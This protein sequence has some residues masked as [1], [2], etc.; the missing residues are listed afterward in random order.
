MKLERFELLPNDIRLPVKSFVDNLD[1]FYNHIDTRPVNKAQ[2][3]ALNYG[4]LEIGNISFKN[5][6]RQHDKIALEIAHVVKGNYF[7]V[8][9]T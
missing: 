5:L 7:N 2:W 3:Q 1:K 4:L 8:L 9:E 6:Y